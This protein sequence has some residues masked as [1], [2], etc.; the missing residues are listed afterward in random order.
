MTRRLKRGK[1]KRRP[2]IQP[3]RYGGGLQNIDWLLKLGKSQKGGFRN[4]NRL[5]TKLGMAIAKGM[6]L[7]GKRF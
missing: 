1:K 7:K 6:G 3:R 2:G 4:V 5:M